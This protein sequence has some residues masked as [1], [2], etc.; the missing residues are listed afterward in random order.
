MVVYDWIS[1]EVAS[2]LT[3][4]LL[5]EVLGYNVTMNTERATESVAGSLQ[6][7]GCVSQDCSERLPRSHVAMD[8]GAGLPHRTPRSF[9]I[10]RLN[11]QRSPKP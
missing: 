1:A 2:E 8:P 5:S 6:L 7:A 4:I 10:T 9:A 3:G 11:L